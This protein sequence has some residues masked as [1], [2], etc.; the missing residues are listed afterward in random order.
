MSEENT[1]PRIVYRK[2]VKM[3]KDITIGERTVPM[4]A[5]ALTPFSYKKIFG[6][7]LIQDIQ[8]LQ[9]GSSKGELD[10]EL[11]CQMTYIMARESDKDILPFEEWLSQ[12]ELFD[13]YESFGEVIQLWGLNEETR[14]TP[15]KK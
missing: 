9:K 13:L 2:D 5:S 7:D 12:F 10:A 8:K 11:V 6:G 1:L 14:S 15:R 3:K 4:S